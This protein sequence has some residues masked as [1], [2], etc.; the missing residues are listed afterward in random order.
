MTT[1]VVSIVSPINGTPKE[2]PTFE[3]EKEENRT[4]NIREHT[5]NVDSNIDIGVNV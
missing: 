3:Y 1:P 4:L 2:V 5:S